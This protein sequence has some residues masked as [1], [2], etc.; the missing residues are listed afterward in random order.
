MRRA[1]RQCTDAGLN[2]G[3]ALAVCAVGWSGALLLGKIDALKSPN[4]QAGRSWRGRSGAAPL[5][6]TQNEALFNVS[7]TT[8]SSGGPGTFDLPDLDGRRLSAPK[9]PPYCR[10]SK[11]ASARTS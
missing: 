11:K 3:I 2:D 7:G 6:G 8:Y 5:S 9:A 1:M 4:F 10:A